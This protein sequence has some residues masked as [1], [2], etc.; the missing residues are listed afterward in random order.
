MCMPARD[1]GI[2]HR[3]QTRRYQE[4]CRQKVR[5]FAS[6]CRQYRHA[7]KPVNSNVG[8][9][10]VTIRTGLLRCRCPMSVGTEVMQ[11]TL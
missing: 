3:P 9:Q 4:K 11:K 8:S 7:K 2:G 6:S 5:E 1:V 10:K